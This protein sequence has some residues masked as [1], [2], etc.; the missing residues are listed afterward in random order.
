MRYF[1]SLVTKMF[2]FNRST[3]QLGTHMSVPSNTLVLS[4]T[5]QEISHRNLQSTGNGPTNQNR[6]TKNALRSYERW[7]AH[8]DH[9]LPLSVNN[10]EV[11]FS[12]HEMSYVLA[13][14]S[15]SQTTL[16]VNVGPHNAM[17]TSAIMTV[18]KS[19]MVP[20][21]CGRDGSWTVRL[22]LY[23]CCFLSHNGNI[24]KFS[25]LL[26]VVDWS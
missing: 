17:S 21:S 10:P 2:S 20:S 19:P 14:S 18:P 5:G 8:S 3:N 7:Q 9:N 4:G 6:V 15:S 23:G 25:L 12:E 22:W 11:I 1:P 16:P 13:V 26:Y 24:L